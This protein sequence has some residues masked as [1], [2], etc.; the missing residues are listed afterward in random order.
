MEKIINAQFEK[1]Q[2]K[3]IQKKQVVVKKLFSKVNG[4]EKASTSSKFLEIIH[5]SF[6]SKSS[7]VQATEKARAVNILVNTDLKKSPGHSDQAVV[8]KKIPVETLAEAVCTTLFEFGIIK[9]IKMQLVRLWQKAMSILIEKNAVYVVRAD[10][11]K[12]SWD[13]KDH[14]RMLLYILFVGGKTCVINHHPVTYAWVR[15]T[16]VCF[17]SVESLDAIMGTIPVLKDT[18]LHWF[19]FMSAKYTNQ[20]VS[21]NIGFFLEMK[22]FLLVV[23]EINDRFAALECSFASLAEHVD[24]LAKRL[25]APEPMVSQL[26]PGCQPLVTPSLQ[27]QG[28]NIMISESLSV[29]TGSEIVVGV[30]I[31]DSS[32]IEKMENTL[33]NFAIIVMGLSA[34]MDNA[35]LVPA[36]LSF[37]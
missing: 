14:H 4:F 15:C 34:K 6:T 30:V 1:L 26:S 3:I 12:E 18:N 7:L 16:V 17:N 21:V 33:K 27:N 29:A 35:N 19:S 5:A 32:V 8:V 37:Q 13:A 22:S 23:M 2:N 20:I 25:E 31:F 9:S 11:D 10:S 24:M 28:M 36:A